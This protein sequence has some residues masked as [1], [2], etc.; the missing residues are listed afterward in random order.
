MVNF[1]RRF[2]PAATRIM[3][4]LFSALTD[5]PRTLQWSDAMVKAFQVAKTALTRATMLT[6][7]RH[8]APT[9]PQWMLKIWWW[10]QFSSSWCMV[11]GNPWHFSANNCAPR[12]VLS[13]VSCSHSTSGYNISDTSWRAG[14]SSCTRT[15]NPSHSAWPKHPTHGQVISSDTSHTSL[16]L[17]RIS[18]TSKART[19]ICRCTVNSHHQH[20]P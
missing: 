1:Y 12:T 2:L 18:G 14:N 16:T 13:T 3:Q 7:P 6:H 15:T 4:P 8:N 10:V 17:P 9:S 5:K 11:F 20:P 19:T